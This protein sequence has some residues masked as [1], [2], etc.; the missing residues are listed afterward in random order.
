MLIRARGL[1]R[2]AGL[3][4]S[5]YA[6]SSYDLLSFYCVT[7]FIDYFSTHFFH[8]PLAHPFTWFP[9]KCFKL[10][11]TVPPF[12][13]ASLVPVFLRHQS[14]P[15]PFPKSTTYLFRE[16]PVT[17]SCQHKVMSRCGSKVSAS[18]ASDTERYSASCLH[19]PLQV[20]QHGSF[21]PLVAQEPSKLFV[22]PIFITGLAAQLQ[23]AISLPGFRVAMGVC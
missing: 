3:S 21:R 14:P 10:S 23:I 8:V 2:V 7:P 5:G 13:I 18:P 12:P 11:S 9:S 1:F 19:P 22:T 4:P 17:F 20:A 6:S 16:S 15:K